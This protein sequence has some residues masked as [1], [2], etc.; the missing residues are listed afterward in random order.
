MYKDL[1]TYEL[2][3][4]ITEDHLISIAKQIIT[5][6]M[7]KQSGFISWEINANSDDGYTDIV[8]WDSKEDAKI[9]EKEMAKIPNA[10]DWFACYKEGSISS[11]NLTQLAVF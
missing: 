11:K 5:D 2:A 4:K 6:W 7:K 1:I 8:T 9:A 10:M 3:E